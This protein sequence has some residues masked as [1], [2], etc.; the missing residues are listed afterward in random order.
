MKKYKLA[1]LCLASASALTAQNAITS[2]GAEGYLSRGLRMYGDKNYT[3]CIDQLTEMKRLGMPES[4]REEADF[5]IALAKFNRNDSDCTDALAAFL[6]NY[7]ASAHRHEIKAAIGDCH[8]YRN[9]YAAAARDYVSVPEDAFDAGARADLIFR[10]SFSHI[11]IKDYG[12]AE[13]GLKKLRGNKRYNAQAAYYLAFIDYAKG[14]YGAAATGF[15]NVGKQSGL[16]EEAQFYLCQIAFDG[17]D[18]AAVQSQGAPLLDGRLPSGM[19]AELMRIVGESD[20]HLGDTGNAASLLEKYLGLTEQAP[21]RSALYILGICKFRNAEYAGALKLFGEVTTDDDE[22]AQS[23]YLYAGQAYLREDNVNAASLAF[24]KAYKMPYDRSVR[25]TAFY[26]YAIAQSKGGRTPFAGS[27]KL[28]RDFLN[29]FPDSRYASDVEDYIISSY[30]SNKDYDNALAS[31]SSIKSPSGKMLRA[32]QEVLY[33]LGVRELGAGNTAKAADYLEQ[34]DKLA[35]YN[36]AVAAETSLWLAE[37]R[38]LQGKDADAETRFAR[39]LQSAGAE[40]ANYAEACYGLGYARFRQRKYS[41]A[42]KA[43]TDAVAA[44]GISGNLKADAY[45]RIADCHYY[46]RNF[47]QAEIFYGKSLGL[48]YNGYA[49]FQ[50]GMMRGLLKDEQGKISIMEQLVAADPQS[51]FAPKAVYEKA[52]AYESLG[53]YGQAASTFESLAATYPQ[54]AEARQG[55]LQLALLLNDMG[56]KDESRKAYETLVRKYPT[57]EEAKVAVDDLKRIY[58]GEG[59]LPEFSRFLKSV[60][61]SYEIDENEIASLTFDAAEKDYLSNGKTDRLKAY[62][63]QYPESGNAG[64][65]AYYIAEAA[66]Q[67]GNGNEALEFAGKALSLAPDAAFAESALG[68]RG[69][70]LLERGEYAQAESD[71]KKLEQRAA[72]AFDKQR[73]QIGLARTADGKEDYNTA[74]RYAGLLLDAGNLTSGLQAEMLYIR[75]NAEMET[76]STDAAVNDYS[77]L[78]DKHIESLHGSMAAIDL[79][80]HYYNRGELKKAEKTVNKLLDSATVHQYWMARGFILLSDIYSK[81]GDKFQAREYLESLQANYPG[82]EADIFAAIEKRLNALK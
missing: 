16:W 80:N 36:P 39:Y 51:D 62:L 38:Y 30:L 29:D 27:M 7:P 50:K 33:R 34:A 35:S 40:S 76:G 45:S 56:K 75:A 6:K 74:K 52:Q 65:C 48:G 14:N 3:G 18:Y 68:M 23:A 44:K 8:F 78:V 25:E 17:K 60:G 77:T 57:S 4:L 21:E 66:Y 15:R 20:Y 63:K 32:K 79:G 55:Q 70:L 11:R 46:A 53:K 72:D 81:Q 1:I 10:K 59:R 9:D 73:A 13:Q 5:Y 82:K 26:N 24:E 69:E 43:F 71:F 67:G 54:S 22:M 31:I 28:F 58:A 12:E 61:S 37:T 2:A 19:K 41:G 47:S 49:L 64:Q 42:L